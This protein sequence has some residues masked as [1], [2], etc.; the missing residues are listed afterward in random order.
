MIRV[1]AV[2]TSHGTPNAIA[3]ASLSACSVSSDTGRLS[4]NS[5]TLSLRG[6]H[7]DAHHQEDVEDDQPQMRE[8]PAT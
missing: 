7:H 3:M 1:A 6:L 5:R 4:K 8:T 2:R